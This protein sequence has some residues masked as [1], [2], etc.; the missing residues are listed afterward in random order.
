MAMNELGDLLDNFDL[1]ITLRDAGCDENLLPMQRAAAN[2]C[3]GMDIND[4]YLSVRELPQAVEWIHNGVPEGRRKLVDVL[5]SE[6]DDFQRAIYYALAGRGVVEQLDTLQWLMRLLKARGQVA[7]ELSRK[8]VYRR[9][10]VSPY[11]AAEPDGPLVAR[12]ATFELGASW[13]ADRGPCPQ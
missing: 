12:T 2:L 1:D 3:I 8:R 7:G 10:L 11:V 9:P 13:S 4:A 6:C 5:G